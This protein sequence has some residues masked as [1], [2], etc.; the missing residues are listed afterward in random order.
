MTH[1]YRQDR[2]AHVELRCPVRPAQVGI[3]L[4]SGWGPRV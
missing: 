4:F 1:S 2:Q 3:R